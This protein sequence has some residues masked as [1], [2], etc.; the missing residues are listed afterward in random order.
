MHLRRHLEISWGESGNASLEMLLFLPL[1]LLFIFISTDTG[2]SF[3]ERATIEDLV[4]STINE[5]RV[6]QSEE[7]VIVLNRDNELEPRGDALRDLLSALAD[8]LSA[9][10]TEAKGGLRDEFADDFGLEV[11]AVAVNIDPETG[12]LGQSPSYQLVDRVLLPELGVENP[13]ANSP[14]GNY[15]SRD[16]FIQAQ[17]GKQTPN[18]FAIPQNLVY[19]TTTSETP[20]LRYFEQTYALYA[21]VRTRANGINRDYVKSVLGNFSSVQVQLLSPLRTQIS[22][23]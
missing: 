18:R 22:G 2:L 14:E 7:A 19:S 9:R 8:E 23:N 1:A 6:I 17:L 21:E 5:E 4:R 11:G 15:V 20:V 3:L 12:A 13:E 10:L 16:Q